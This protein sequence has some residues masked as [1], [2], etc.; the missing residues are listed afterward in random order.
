M[1][2][3]PMKAEAGLGLYVLYL[4]LAF[5]LRSYVQWRRTGSTG[6]VGVKGRPG[7]VEWLSGAL[8]ALAL[9]L[10]FAAPALDLA[11]VLDPL[12]GGTW[13]GAAFTVIGIASTLIA[14]MAMGDSWRI[15]VDPGERTEL[16]TTGPF[17]HV[18]NPIF[19]AMLQTSIGLVLLVPN[20]AAIAGFVALLVALELQTRVVEE[21]YL[22]ATHGEA[23][24][25][26]ARR[27]GRFFP[28][29]GRLRSDT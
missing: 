5:G 6:F 3:T 21:P 16:V 10:G 13:W 9:V 29:V 17:S 2:G 25:R 4:L 20:V 24:A 27:A 15:G 14:Q 23:Y 7:S 26:Y 11:G 28:G 12:G 18:R 1:E 19:G 22:L 8:F